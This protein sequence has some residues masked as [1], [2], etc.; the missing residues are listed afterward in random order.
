MLPW[1]ALPEYLNP[2]VLPIEARPAERRGSIDLYL[3]EETQ[4]RPAVVFVHGGPIPVDLRPTPREWPV[5]QGYG[6]LAAAR[7]VVG[8]TVDHRLH[9]L[10]SYPLA[11]A[12]VAAAVEQARADPRVDADRVAIWLF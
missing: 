8:V 5:Y 6:S 10:A 2:F 7:G 3:P 1:V 4:P 11:A 9:D 12:D